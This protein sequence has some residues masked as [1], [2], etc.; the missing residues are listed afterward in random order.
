[1]NIA[2]GI[3]GELRTFKHTLPFWH[4]NPILN[5]DYYVSTWDTSTDLKEY[6]YNNLE[7]VD[8]SE[9]FPHGLVYNINKENFY[10]EIT[11]SVINDIVGKEIV[12]KVH[13]SSLASEYNGSNAL[14]HMKHCMELITNSGKDYDFVILIRPDLILSINSLATFIPGTLYIPGEIHQVEGVSFMND[15]YWLGDVNTV[16]NFLDGLPD[17]ITHSHQKYAEYLT[18][19]DINFTP[20]DSD[21]NRIYIS[22]YPLR[23]SNI[24][25]LNYLAVN[26]R[27][28]FRDGDWNEQEFAIYSKHSITGADNLI[29]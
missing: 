1:M 8:Y 17:I 27:N 22:P 2:I 6:I 14:F 13:S 5:I 4:V 28:P 23:P 20:F 7:E 15:L 19:S 26:N 29:S 21:I 16:K 11:E 10:Q 24:P 9:D 18:N 12:S 3:Y 25:F